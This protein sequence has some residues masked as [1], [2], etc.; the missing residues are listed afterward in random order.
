MELKNI[1]LVSDSYMCSNCGAC[2]AVCPK[3]AIYF[4]ISNI[5]RMYAAVS[6]KC[7]NCGLCTKVC[8][9]LEINRQHNN[10]DPYVGD[11]ISVHVGRATD[12]FTYK[13]S[14]SGGVCTA[15]LTYL[16]DNKLIDGALVVR[17]EA[18]TPVPI[19]RASIVSDV[20]SLKQSQKS[21]YTPIDLLSSL[22]DI[23]QYNSLAVVGLPCHIS[24]LVNLQKIKKLY[25]EKI[26]Y[27]IG[28]ICDRT[29]CS[30]IQNVFQTYA[31]QFNN[32]IINWRC[33]N[34]SNNGQHYQYDNAPVVIINEDGKYVS[35]KNLHRFWLKEMFTPPRCR[36]CT[37]K[38]NVNADIVLGDPW[39][40]PNYDK[41]NGDSVIAVRTEVGSKL[42]SDA[43]KAGYI[44]CNQRI[45]EEIETGQLIEQRRIQVASYSYAL[46]KMNSDIHNF[47]PYTI[48]DV[49]NIHVENA[50]K[51]LLQ[52]CNLENRDSTEITRYAKLIISN[53]EKRIRY[54]RNIIVRI[55][56]KL[57]RLLK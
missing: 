26:K 46:K 35:V 22:K 20:A 3:N 45:R 7:V 52:F 40:M 53:N 42:F 9:S 55:I 27:R 56:R 32:I 14:Q 28:L 29:L 2:N 13:N 25:A 36:V 44:H 10:V 30:G 4:K 11:I 12:D 38:I 15:L 24:G 51:N 1:G 18:S 31:P 49:S 43:C 19:L 37:D 16:F 6:D 50:T 23:S 17:M 8:P 48:T 41:E 5:G 57:K 54:D 21:C 39:R 34:L 33:K 47:I